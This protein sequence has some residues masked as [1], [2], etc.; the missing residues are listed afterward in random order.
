MSDLNRAGIVRVSTN[1]QRI[2]VT[3]SGIRYGFNG[4]KLTEILGADT[5]HGFMGEVAPA[6]IEFSVTDHKDL[7]VDALLSAQDATVTAELF[8]GKTLVL[9]QASNTSDRTAQSSDGAITLRYVGTSLK[10]LPA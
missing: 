1:G 3:S 8:N 5:F 2:D 4:A 7:D 6:F 10:E 9:S